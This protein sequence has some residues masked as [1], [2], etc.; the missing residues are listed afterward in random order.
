MTAIK[1][2]VGSQNPVKIKAVKN[3]FSKVFGDCE[4]IGVKVTSGIPDMPMNLTE[5]IKGARN[6]A[7]KAIRKIPADF[8]VGLEGGLEET[9]VGTFIC[10]FVAIVDCQSRWGF[11]KGSGLLLPE[12]IV[13]KVKKGKELGK[14]MDELTG[15]TNVKQKQGALGFFTKNLIPRASGFEHTLILALARFMRKKQ[16]Q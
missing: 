15:E 6:R 2:V 10:G 4:V 12:K 13:Q 9:K 3:A 8:G 11:G 14:V 16:Y 5:T 7:K 1:V